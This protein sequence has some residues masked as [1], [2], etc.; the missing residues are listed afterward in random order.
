MEKSDLTGKKVLIANWKSHKTQ[1]DVV[2]FFEYLK[3]K[4]TKVNLEDKEIIIAPPF[5]LLM[6]CKDLIEEYSLPIKLAS[7]NVS[8][9]P[10]GAYTGEINAKQIK[11]LAEYVIIAHSERRKYMHENEA[12]IE[13][14]VREATEEGLHVIQCIQDEAGVIHK[15]AG[16]V[17]YEPPTAIGSGNPDSPEHVSEVF[18]AIARD[19]V[20]ARIL[21]GGSVTA[22]NITDYLFI[23]RLGGFLIGGASL[24]A[25]S[26][27]SLLSW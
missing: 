9:Y 5:T 19:N 8:S 1:Q 25:S 12:D 2:A 24:D 23:K 7:Q 16:I 14:K 20:G 13:N 11:E 22:D 10:E 17:A 26:F 4:I 15:G 27:L 21:Y 6:Q 3:D 18:D